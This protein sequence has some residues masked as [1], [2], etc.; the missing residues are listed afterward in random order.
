MEYDVS[1]HCARS[2][3]E[4]VP[5]LHFPRC[6]GRHAIASPFVSDRMH[7]EQF[8]SRLGELDRKQVN[9]VLWTLYWRG[10]ATLRQ[11]IEAGSRFSAWPPTR[12]ADCVNLIPPTR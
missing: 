9:T 3:G 12:S 8:Y 7:R 5:D 1:R 2:T 6:R 11:R 10:S 4:G